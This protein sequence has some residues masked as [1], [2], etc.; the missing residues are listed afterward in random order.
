MVVPVYNQ[1]RDPCQ[2]EASIHISCT[3][4][5]KIANI[6]LKANIC[7]RSINLEQTDVFLLGSSVKAQWH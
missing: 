1:S 5:V 2:V 7:R 3:A 4:E 6:G